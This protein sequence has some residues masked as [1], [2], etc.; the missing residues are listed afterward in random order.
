MRYSQELQ[1]KVIDE[2]LSKSAHE[3]AQEYNV[4]ERLVKKWIFLS[5]P[6]EKLKYTVRQKFYNLFPLV[7]AKITTD[8]SDSDFI[9]C[10]ITDDEWEEL[11]KKISKHL[12]DLAF[13]VYKAA[14]LEDRTLDSI[15]NKRK[16]P[17][18]AVIEPVYKQ[19]ELVF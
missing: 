9:V 8:L 10:S 19:L 17:D 18:K 3:V 13:A 4:P 12:F 1:E 5:I 11:S 15:A 7:E 14:M 6:E 2:S 16:E